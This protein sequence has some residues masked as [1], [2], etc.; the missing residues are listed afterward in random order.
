MDAEVTDT[1]RHVLIVTGPE[2]ERLYERFATLFT[3]RVDVEVIKDRRRGQRRRVGAG[4]RDGER[5]GRERRQI[6]PEWV[7]PPE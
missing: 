3:G 2:R 7:V 4:P 1:T 6:D 5:R